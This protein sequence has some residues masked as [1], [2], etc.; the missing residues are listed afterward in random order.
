M[1]GE[2]AEVSYLMLAR[3][4][5]ESDESREEAMRFEVDVRRARACGRSEGESHAAI[6]SLL[7]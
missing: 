3:W 6:A 2:D 7:A 1:V 4:R 5:D